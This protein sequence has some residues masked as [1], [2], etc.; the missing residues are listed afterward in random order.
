MIQN[1]YEPLSTADWARRTF[2][3]L[4]LCILILTIVFAVSEFRFDWGEKLIGNYLLSTNPIRPETGALWEDGR[5]TSNAHESLNKIITRREDTRRDVHKA[6]SFFHL[7]QS[8][9]PG[10]W[11]TLDKELF[12]SLYLSL[13]PAIGR[14][15]IDPAQ[16]VWLLNTKVTDRIFCEGLMEGIKIYFID[17]QNRVIHGIDL[18]KETILEIESRNTPVKGKL[19]E[20]EAFSSRIYLAAEFFDAVFKLSPEMISDLIV[21]PDLLLSQEGTIQKVG[22]WNEA[23]GGYIKLGFEFENRGQTRVLMVQAREWA[24]WQL[25][26]VLKGD[27]Q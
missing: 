21:D 19:E 3:F 1:W 12:K 17:S 25:S 10:E 23:Q 13:S 22:I 24:V 11:V 2:S 15:I 7:A 14:Q 5:Q 6:S 20:I 27:E 16:V 9:L 4:N 18:K 26:L 8:L